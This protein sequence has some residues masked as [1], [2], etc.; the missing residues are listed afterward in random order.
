M[1]TGYRYSPSSVSALR[2]ERHRAY[3]TE[4]GLPRD[5][6]L[7]DPT[8][9]V[10]RSVAG[11]DLLKIGQGSEDDWFCVDEASGEVVSLLTEF[12]KVQHVNA[13]PEAFGQ[14]LAEFAAR[15]PFGDQ[16]S[17]LNEREDL[18][19]HFAQAMN[20]VDPSAAP[21]PADDATE[22]VYWLDIIDDIEIGDYAEE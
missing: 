5:H 14:C 6:L 11:R 22:Q 19:R 16:E 13:S 9:T 3:L 18:A 17:Y 20:R 8:E 2:D 15:Y 21:D 1:T 10:R 12:G 4:V 7:F